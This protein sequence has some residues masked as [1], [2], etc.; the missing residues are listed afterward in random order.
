MCPKEPAILCLCPQ[1]N[2]SFS[3]CYLR[4]Y[5]SR[6]PAPAFPTPLSSSLSISHPLSG[7]SMPFLASPSPSLFLSPALRCPGFLACLVYFV[8]VDITASPLIPP[9]RP[10]CRPGTGFP[11]WPLFPSVL[12]S[13]FP[14]VH[15]LLSTVPFPICPLSPCHLL[16]LPLLIC[17]SNYLL[18][19]SEYTVIKSKLFSVEPRLLLNVLSFMQLFSL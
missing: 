11:S 15:R 2:P 16:F 8:E 4:P 12:T 7:S 19:I 18:D 13:P 6:T 14:F 3:A 1:A 17:T 5:S 9:F 10:P